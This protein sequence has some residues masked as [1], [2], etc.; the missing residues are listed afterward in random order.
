[1]ATVEELA[2][3]VEGVVQGD[4]RAEV[5]G[6]NDLERA[7][8]GEITFLADAKLVDKLARCRASA[9]ITTPA[10][11]PALAP[12]LAGQES[13]VGRNL[14]LVDNP[15]LAATRIQNHL[16]AQPFVATGIH[17][18][19]VI[20]EDCH[21]PGEVS[22]GPGVVLG[23]GVRLGQRVRLAAGV[24]V[25]DEV[26]IG[27][28]VTIHPNVTIYPRSIIGNRVVVHGGT[29]LGSDGF[30]YATDRQ[31]RHHKRPHL[32]LVRIEDDVE[33][34]ANC[35]I[36]RGTFGETVIKAGSK[37][38]NLVQIGHNVVVGEN[39][40]LVAQVGIAGSTV[41]ERHV[42]VGGQVGIAGHLRIGPGVMMAAKS[43]VHNNQA[44]GAVIAGIPAI[45]HKQWLRVSAATGKLPDLLR[46]VRDLR[47]QVAAL[48]AG[49]PAPLKQD[50]ESGDE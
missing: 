22:I 36:D 10:L 43:G 31:G 8:Q 29:V 21:L 50:K 20:G 12:I 23:D 38:D 18:R 45:N 27:D 37:I 28:D 13:G 26:S 19:A 40:L 47:R 14:I 16:L 41:L 3:L 33:I 35:C 42:V 49:Q 32:G 25:G 44:A 5:A 11:A 34:G 39:S 17:P 15:Y 30:G 24:V 7:K 2:A 9:L 46:Q 48:Q 6:F 4:G 1:M